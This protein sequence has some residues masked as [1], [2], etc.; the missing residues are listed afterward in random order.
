M[1]GRSNAARIDRTPY[2]LTTKLNYKAILKNAANNKGTAILSAAEK[3]S[4]RI[5]LTQL[6]KAVDEQQTGFKIDRS[7]IDQKVTLRINKEK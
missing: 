2:N 3:V 7:C 6:L 1:E 4:N 5:Q